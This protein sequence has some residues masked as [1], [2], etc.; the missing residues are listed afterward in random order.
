MAAGSPVEY[1]PFIEWRDVRLPSWANEHDRFVSVKVCG[2]SLLHA[3]RAP[4]RSGDYALVHLTGDVREGDLA[5]VLTPRG[6]TLKFI[7]NEPGGRIR[8]EPA[9]PAF[10]V[11]YFDAS[12]VTIQ[13]RVVRTEHDW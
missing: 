6:M 9:N 1:L 7:F 5:A 11:E 12:E 3:P 10:E 8:L 13:G 4:V 2:D